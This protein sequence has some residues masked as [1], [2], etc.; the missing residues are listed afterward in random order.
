VNVAP[1]SAGKAIG[2]VHKTEKLLRSETGTTMAEYVMLIVLVC[3]SVFMLAPN[4]KSAIVKVF[5][6][7]SS[8]L[9]TGSGS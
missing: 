2:T 4:T 9:T 6:N 8:A 5:S 1:P 3:L 7:T